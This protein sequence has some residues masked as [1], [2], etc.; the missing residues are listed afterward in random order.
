[1]GGT[2]PGS[3]PIARTRGRTSMTAT[4]GRIRYQDGTKLRTLNLG[5]IGVGVGGTEML[6][7]MD[8]MDEL[9]VMACADINPVTRGFF[10][11]RYPESHVYET[12]EELCKDPDVEVVW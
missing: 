7:P 10:S 3:P 5:M 4:E 9:N 1:M 11:E 12:A 6:P 2:P 8:A